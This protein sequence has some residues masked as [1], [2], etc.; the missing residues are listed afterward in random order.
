MI[1]KRRNVTNAFFT[2]CVLA[3]W[4]ALAFT[5]SAQQLPAEAGATEPTPPAAASDSATD[6]TAPPTD[7]PSP[8]TAATEAVPPAETPSIPLAEEAPPISESEETSL[9]DV[10]QIH[11][12]G[13]WRAGITD[14][15]NEYLFGEKKGRFESATFSLVVNATPFR[16]LRLVAAQEIGIGELGTE[17][18][19][20]LDFA[21]A[22]LTITDVLKVKI[23]VGPFPVGLSTEIYDVGTLRP[24]LALPQSVYGFSGVLGENLM[25][26]QVHLNLP[27]GGTA[28]LDLT[29]FGGA[30]QF[31]SRLPFAVLSLGSGASAED[32]AALA[33]EDVEAVPHLVGARAILQTG[34]DG[35]SIGASG[36]VGDNDEEFATRE[37]SWGSQHKAINGF[38]VFETDTLRLQLEYLFGDLGGA[39]LNGGYVEARYILSSAWQIAARGDFASF[40]PD[41]STRRA[42]SLTRHVDVALGLSYWVST[43]FTL[44]AAYHYVMGNLYAHPAADLLYTAVQNRSL[45]DRTHYG[46]LGMAFSF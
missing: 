29:I 25:G 18:D 45:N 17:P 7:I 38:L 11:G 43:D 27:L 39:T 36:Y 14:S 9:S 22:E 40:D 6:S 8:S 19:L 33:E 30:A 31:G 3:S 4:L 46:E 28:E 42:D 16:F 34:I 41:E 1:R 21:F 2:A 10:L 12:Y 32:A 24:F 23:G 15:D 37:E 5:T 13:G 44:Q 26:I 20:E 35:L